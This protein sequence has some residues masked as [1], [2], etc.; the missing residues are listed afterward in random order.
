MIEAFVHFDLNNTFPTDRVHFSENI[1]DDK[2]KQLIVVRVNLWDCFWTILNKKIG[3]FLNFIMRNLL[4]LAFVSR[5]I[6]YVIQ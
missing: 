3:I 5:E 1:T 6:G 2:I 4:K